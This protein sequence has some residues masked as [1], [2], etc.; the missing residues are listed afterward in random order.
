M[1]PSL[2]G[3]RGFVP[4]ASGT[5]PPGVTLWRHPPRWRERP[6]T[7]SRA[8]AVRAVGRNGP[9]AVSGSR[10]GGGRRAGERAGPDNET[11]QEACAPW[12]VG[13]SSAGGGRR[14]TLHAAAFSRRIGLPR[15]SSLPYGAPRLTVV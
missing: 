13:Q 6:A 3:F 4:Q 5:G 7:H 12:V 1:G 8:G 2:G 14:L 11:T 9:L 15:R 10:S